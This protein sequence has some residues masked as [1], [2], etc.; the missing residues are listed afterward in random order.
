MS[1]LC[2]GIKIFKEDQIEFSSEKF[3]WG[4]YET[5]SKHP[6]IKIG[7]VWSAIYGCKALV[8][9]VH[10]LGNTLHHAHI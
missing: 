1:V 8:L 7:R 4:V 10:S 9:G 2:A 3:F 6:F 5:T